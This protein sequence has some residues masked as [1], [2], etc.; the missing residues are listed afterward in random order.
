MRKL[1]VGKGS[2]K[3]SSERG[4]QD[5]GSSLSTLKQFAFAAI[6]LYFAYQFAPKAL[7][8]L[9]VW[10][11]GGGTEDDV[12]DDD[13]E[14]ENSTSCF[15]DLPAQSWPSKAVGFLQGNVYLAS[16]R[17]LYQ[18]RY[19][20]QAEAY[21]LAASA[22]RPCDASIHYNIGSLRYD[23]EDHD[24]AEQSFR[25]ALK[26][27]PKHTFSTL[28][29]SGMEMRRGQVTFWSSV[30]AIA[31]AQ[32]N[33]MKELLNGTSLERIRA[34]LRANSSVA[35]HVFE[36][37]TLFQS[38][39][40]RN[41]AMVMPPAIQ[42]DVPHLLEQ[43]MQTFKDLSLES[44]RAAQTVA[45][46]QAL[47]EIHELENN[48]S[49]VVTWALERLLRFGDPANRTGGEYGHTW[50]SSWLQA[51]KHERAK[52]AMRLRPGNATVVIVGS[53]L[54]YQCLFALVAGAA[55]C[56][57]YDLMCRS[58]V[59]P[60]T[61]IVTRH[62]LQDS[63]TFVCG[64]SRRAQELSEASLVWMNDAMFPP[65]VRDHMQQLLV[66][67][68][69]HEAVGITYVAPTEEL[70]RKAAL[71]VVDVLRV[72]LSWTT[73]AGLYIL[74]KHPPLLKAGGSANAKRPSQKGRKRKRRGI[75]EL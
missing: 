24:G 6:F 60:A 19:A 18:L 59:E 49:W 48:A 31:N 70:W 28:R 43:E 30:I 50:L 73:S 61:E 65:Q 39:A 21:Y 62:G 14:E 64:D 16:A 57:G 53:G 40:P 20:R 71:Q 4:R 47:Q 34:N 7:R 52:Q 42:H 9:Q 29:L 23:R 25:A 33:I 68:L 17:L 55:R 37:D 63:I 12:E 56:I 41:F 69:P 36:L 11:Q 54:G 8:D 3:G 32:P 26:A 46:S 1:V 27:D 38:T 5:A 58:L 75:P 66:Q 67:Q 2:R 22:H 15:D 72:M 44:S 35:P 10:W 51:M 45:L 74:L 13:T